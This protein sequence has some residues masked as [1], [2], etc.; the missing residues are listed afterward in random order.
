MILLEAADDVQSDAILCEART[1]SEEDNFMHVPS[2][3]FDP[4]E[5]F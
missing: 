3:G 2:G 5:F 1:E 4:K